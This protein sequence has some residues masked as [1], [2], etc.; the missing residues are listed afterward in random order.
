MSFAKEMLDA[1]KKLKGLGHNVFM[2]DGCEKYA[3]GNIK[4]GGDEGAK[5]KIENDLIRKHYNLISESEAI[6]V[7]NHEKRGIKNYIGGNAFLEMGF[8]H[9]LDKKIFLLNPAPETDFMAQEIQAMRPVVLGGDLN[10]IL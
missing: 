5:R 7:L 9:I 1:E 6:L 3:Q 4:E 8:A 10:K 2:P